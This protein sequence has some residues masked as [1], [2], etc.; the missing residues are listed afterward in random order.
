MEIHIPDLCLVALVGASGSGKSTFAAT[1]FLPTEVVSSDAC[2]GMVADDPNDQGASGDAFEL[3]HTIAGIRLR[4]GHLTVID[5]TNVQRHAR[6]E[7]VQLAR[8]HDVLPVAIVLDVP[9]EVCQERNDARPD[10]DF[11]AHVVKNHT[12]SLRRSLRHLKREGFRR[13]HVLRGVEAIDDVSIVRE[14]LWNDRRSET[15]PFDIIGDIHGCYDELRELLGELGWIVSEDDDGRP[16]GATHPEDRTL[17]FLGDLVDRGPK[18]PDVLRLAMAMV[19]AGTAICVNGNHE[20]KLLRT[21]D[22][23]NVRIAHGLAETLEQL[24]AEDDAF[25]Q[26]V[27]DFLR[28]LISHYRLDGGGLVVAHAGLIEK[29]QGR[30][31]GRVRSFCL[32]GETTG[33]IDSFG[34]PVRADWAAEY[35]GSASVVYGHTPMPAAEWVNN[36]ICL[37]TGCVFGGRLTALRWPERQLVGVDAHEVWCEPIRPL[38]PEGA[39]DG[40]AQQAAD[41]LLHL[42][43]IRGTYRVETRLRGRLTIPEERGAAALEMIS[44]FAVDPRWLVYL[45]PTMSPSETSSQD[46]F[47]EHPTEAFAYFRKAGVPTVVCEEKHM[48][49]RAVVVVCRDEAVGSRRFG[50]AGSGVVYTRTGRRFFGDASLEGAVLDRVRD[51]IDG[52]GLWE[53]LD[54]DWVVLDC[55]LM[56]WSAKAQELIRHQYAPV[57]AAADA[58]FPPA[59][60]ALEGAAARL[61]GEEGAA[62]AELLARFAERAE[63]TGRYRA[64]W[65][66]YCWEVS[67][68]DDYRLAPFHVLATEG[69]C[70]V[71]KT[72]AWH[73]GLA[74]RL[75]EAGSDLLMATPWRS[76]DLADPAQVEAA[77]AWWLERTADGGEGM[78]VKPADFVARGAKG[79]LQP[80]VKCRGREYLRIIYGPEYTAPEHLDRLRQRGLG[81]K[82]S[83]ALR[84]FALGVEGLERFV[85]G[86]PLRRVHECVFGVVALESEP[87]DPR[88]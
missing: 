88:L 83:L 42:A 78:V 43:D 35:R 44:R 1:H 79:L 41:R 33:E 46:G 65:S 13:V 57:G 74:A 72:H 9:P 11:G 31:S 34:L 7:L 48:G 27:R 61:D 37:D 82:R 4:R 5:A 18:V 60:A 3:V 84:E 50:I 26:A 29:Y 85:A 21:L 49:S 86:A 12:R 76:V 47:L 64:A 58:A 52:A 40:T 68:P 81:R 45:P 15:G 25:V 22:G 2:R 59:L 62:A 6:E 73:M 66:P 36:T 54:T 39:E 63:L 75:A 23:R 51:A 69:A 10:R 70:H 24:E 30:A 67:D 28:G 17:V 53:E 80:A 55:E 20:A 16:T 56:P 77:T 87:V 19:E 14:P 71:D 32:Y 38:V 8:D